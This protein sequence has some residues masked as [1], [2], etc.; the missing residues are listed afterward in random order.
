MKQETHQIAVAGPAEATQL[1]RLCC[2]QWA[3][4]CAT[5]PSSFVTNIVQLALRVPHTWMLWLHRQRT[6]C[7][8]AGLLELRSPQHQHHQQPLR[9]RALTEGVLAPARAHRL[10]FIPAATDHKA[11]PARRA[12]AQ[13]AHM[14]QSS[15]D[16][17][18]A[19]RTIK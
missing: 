11:R 17:Y 14:Q 1:G 16:S 13:A 15:G 6:Q 10:Q 9:I 3:A 4:P 2:R 12:A 8:P 19:C 18:K 5:R 7:H